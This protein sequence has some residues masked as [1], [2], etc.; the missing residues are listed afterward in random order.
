MKL[1]VIREKSEF[2]SG[3]Q[4]FIFDKKPTLTKKQ[5]SN[6]GGVTWKDTA[7]GTVETAGYCQQVSGTIG[8]ALLG[9]VERGKVYELS[10]S[11]KPVVSV[12]GK[13]KQVGK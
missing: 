6:D 5:V 13:G 11:A 12:A 9:L 4:Y 2:G 10:L 3:E 1:Y 7:D 8:K